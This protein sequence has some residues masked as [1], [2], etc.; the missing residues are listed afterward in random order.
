MPAIDDGLQHDRDRLR[1]EIERAV[2]EV[3]RSGRRYRRASMVLLLTGRPAGIA[4][5][6]GDGVSTLRRR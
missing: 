4:R 3:R 6:T 2:Q 5:L 1:D